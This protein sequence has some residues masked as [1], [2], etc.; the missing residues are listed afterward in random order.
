[1]ITKDQVSALRG[2]ADDRSIFTE[3]VNSDPEFKAGVDRVRVKYPEMSGF[4]EMKFSSA[5]LDLYTGR[6][7]KKTMDPSA[8]LLVRATN[9]K[10]PSMQS[11]GEYVYETAS[12]VIPSTINLLGNVA[13]LVR[14]PIETGKTAFK[15]GVGGAANTIETIAALA[16]VK[17]AE[18]IFDLES[19]EVANAVGDFYVQRYGSLE[20]AATTLRD[21]PAG[22]L[23]DIGAVVSGVG[24]I[25]KG[26]AKA[27]G[28]A[29]GAAT[30]TATQLS[31]IGRGL[32]TAQSV[33][34]KMIKT[35][36][37]M[38]PI[39]IAGKGTVMAGRG[40]RSII[41]ASGPTAMTERLITSSLRLHPNQIKNFENFNGESISQF[42]IRKG[43]LS[44]G[45]DII[46]AGKGVQLTG[47]N[48]F[49][50]TKIGMM[51]DLERIARKAKSTVDSDLARIQQTYDI[52]DDAP[53]VLT[54]LSE[55]QETAKTYG[56][57]DDLDFVNGMINKERLSLTDINAVKRRMDDLYNLYSSTNEP[58]ASL[59]AE[60]LRRIRKKIKE[61]I[62]VE[63]ERKGLPYIGLLNEDTQ[64]ATALLKYAERA[65]M[66]GMGRNVISLADLVTGS[67]TFGITRSP[68]ATVGIVVSR[69][70]LDSAPFK[71][72]LAKFM[73]RLTKKQIDALINA[74]KTGKHTKETRFLLRKVISQTADDLQSN[75]IAEQENLAGFISYQ[76]QSTGM[77]EVSPQRIENPSSA[78]VPNTGIDVNNLPITE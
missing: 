61:F 52:I 19:E 6:K 37:N 62:E 46:N 2:K 30:R 56:L 54:A 70:V 75:K 71:M 63:A 36:V 78:Y 55:L 66:S 74:V 48:P 76:K 7:S 18:E 21:D 10:S 14:H 1:M 33:G 20:K 53:E 38:E 13:G 3:L 50:R 59:V 23:S 12:N 49:G 65:A 34:E 22:F 42:M 5:M 25:I 28:S 35:G 58:S 57:L 60:R 41:R 73:N 8:E 31:S 77:P 72:T 16:G 68:L 39:I 67:T 47:S 11:V 26:G 43:I 44:G 40:V 29:S 69:R 24:G 17:N 64:K 4:E 9:K 45:D 51:D 27:V 15:L 32:R